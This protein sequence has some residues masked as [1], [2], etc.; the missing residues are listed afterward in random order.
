MTKTR[1]STVVLIGLAALGSPSPPSPATLKGPLIHAGG[2]TLEV[3]QVDFATPVDLT[4][5]VAF[6]LSREGSTTA[7]VN[8]G[9]NSV[10]RF[11]NMQSRAGVP[12][13]QLKL[14]VVVHGGAVV[15]LLRDDEYRKRNGAD[16]PNVALIAEL[17]RAG[18]DILICGQTAAGRGLK[19]DQF[20]EPAKVALSAMT[21]FAVL[22]ERGYHVNPF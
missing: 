22:Q 1:L 11:L 13:N 5:R 15:D 18:V 3:P 14:A 7:T 19:A 8:P 2:D 21:A 4:Y 20:L 9:L 10:A 12:L 6:D 16:N 17:S